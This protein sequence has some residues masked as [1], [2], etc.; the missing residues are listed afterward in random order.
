MTTTP[1]SEAA[2][3]M[4]QPLKAGFTAPGGMGGGGLPGYN[5]YEARD[6]WVAVA[7]LEPHFKKRMDEALGVASRSPEELRPVFL[8]KGAVEWEEWAKEYD[9]PVVAVKEAP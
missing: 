1:L 7:A 2:D 5:L 9:L 3:Y 4:A 8:G 6:G